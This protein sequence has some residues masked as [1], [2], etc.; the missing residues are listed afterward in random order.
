MGTGTVQLN[1]AP[2]SEVPH[3]G[4]MLCYC[5]LDII[6]IFIFELVICMQN[7]CNNKHMPGVWKLDLH[8]VLPPVGSQLPQNDSIIHFPT[9]WVLLGPVFQAITR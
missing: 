1:Q 7:V 3:I 9:A 4:L 8:K 6:N 5:P 2:F